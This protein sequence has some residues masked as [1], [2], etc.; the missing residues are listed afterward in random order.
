MVYK[1]Q[2]LLYMVGGVDQ[3]V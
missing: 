3:D 2:T 1:K